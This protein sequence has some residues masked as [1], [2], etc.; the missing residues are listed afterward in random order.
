[1][2]RVATLFMWLLYTLY[3]II[4]DMISYLHMLHLTYILAVLPHLTYQLETLYNY[5][6]TCCSSTQTPIM[7][8]PHQKAFTRVMNS[9]LLMSLFPSKTP[10]SLQEHFQ[11]APSPF[12][13]WK[14]VQTYKGSM[15]F[16]SNASSNH[17]MPSVQ[18]P[19]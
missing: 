17:T 1:M 2:N 12:K 16:P 14:P 4:T 18:N 11:F 10:V 3:D 19:I 15:T 7:T 9:S 13:D 6:Y 8:L 5:T